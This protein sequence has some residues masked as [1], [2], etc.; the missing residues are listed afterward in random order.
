MK[1]WDLTLQNHEQRLRELG[2]VQQLDGEWRKPKR[3]AAVVHSAPRSK[4]EPVA[5]CERDDRVPRKATYPGRV[6]ISITS[7]VCG[8]LR[9]EDNICP[10]FFIDCLRHAGLIRDDCPGT[11]ELEKIKEVRVSTKKEE[12]CE[13]VIT[14]L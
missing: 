5:L 9:D 4:P 8:Q 1:N 2:F 14:P 3:T 7:Y 12:G 10:K 13:I 11:V 6:R